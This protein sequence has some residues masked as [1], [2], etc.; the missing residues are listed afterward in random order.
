M[1]EC[2][3]GTRVGAT[4]G[5]GGGVG[6]R[7]ADAQQQPRGVA[8]VARAVRLLC[9]RLGRRLCRTHPRS[10]EQQRLVHMDTPGTGGRTTP[11]ATA[12]ASPSAARSSCPPAARSNTFV[13]TVLSLPTLPPSYCCPYPCP[14]CTLPPFSPSFL[15]LPLPV[16]LLYSPSLRG[17][18]SSSHGVSAIG[19]ARHPPPLP[20][21][22]T[23][24]VSSL[25]PYEPDTSRGTDPLHATPRFAP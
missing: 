19:D 11:A 17:M 25:L 4:G 6:E 14:Y 3:V 2:T 12:S 24:H 20:P 15:L 22:L 18:K 16:S 10:T 23:G 13:P 1:S 21:V 5:K 7:L 9:L 8:R